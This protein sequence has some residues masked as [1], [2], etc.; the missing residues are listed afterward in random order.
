MFHP[1]TA[2]QDARYALRTLKKDLRFFV[3]AMLIIGLGIGASTAVF[4]V[5]SPLLLRPLGFAEPERLVWVANSGT[6]GMSAVTSRTSN[7]R[8][9]RELNTSF[10]GLTGYFAFFEA[11]SYNLVGDGEPERLVAVDVAHDFLDVLGVQPLHGRNFVPEEGLW[12]G[13][14]AVVLSHAFWSRRFSADPEIVGTSIALNNEPNEVVGVLPPSFDFA[15]TFAPHTRID[16]LRPFPISDET[17]R[18]G[19]TLSMI[20]RLKP[21][22]STESAQA[23]LD[24]IIAGLQEAD[25]ERWGLG[26]AVSPLQQQ[27]AGPFRAGLLLL[28]AAAAVVMLIVCVNLSNLLLVKAPKR[29]EEMAVR[30][31]LG[32]PRGRLLRQ[33]LCESLLLTLGGAIVGVLFA[34]AITRTVAAS[35]AIK[36]PLL[37]TVSVDGTALLFALLAALVAGLLVGIVPALRVSSGGVASILGGNSRGSSGSARST[38]LLEAL[39]VAEV[40]LACVLLVCGGLLLKSFNKV[41]DVELGFQPT[42]LVQWQI[43]TGRDFESPAAST[44]FFRQMIAGVEAIPGVEAAGLTDAAPLGRNRTWTL[45]APGVEYE[46]ESPWLF[47]FPH[48]VDHG[49][50]PTMQIPLVAGRHFTAHDTDTSQNVIILNESAAQAVYLGEDPL[51]RTVRS[52]GTEFEVVGI[53]ADVRHRSLEES[54]GYEMYFPLAQ[55]GNFS[56]LDL[57]VRS[58]LPESTLAPSVSSA[59][60]AV[61]PNMPTRDHQTLDAIVERAV[62]PRRF[63]LSLLGAFAG[64]ALLLAALG[65]YGVLSYSV[66]ERIPEI[67]IRMALGESGPQVL[68]RVVSKTLLLTGIGVA[69]GAAGSFAASRLLAS[70]LY[71]VQPTDP[72]TF[73]TMAVVLLAVATL[74][75]WIPA[76]KAARTDPARAL[77]S[78]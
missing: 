43:N 78:V 21:G 22:A 1:A 33:M 10:A 60:R 41:L 73:L 15:S 68:R 14:R 50:L 56:T 4:S 76:L 19:N 65:I 48:I 29:S 55:M 17:D 35:T 3:F 37:R 11:G 54:S 45:G 62:S 61:D 13:P 46:E 52:G 20:G 71:D 8:D 36:I 53:V 38:R 47:T 67:G 74:A 7:L 9:F 57:I 34:T 12:G 18:W 28:A 31:A 59:L 51:G 24:L 25:P 49:Y 2:V 5:M 16:F 44:A 64:V 77:R 23:E 66:A 69:V 27:I 70:L 58:R 63:T 32:A 39:V 75:G 30:T 26:A 72:R 6:G 40:A 42:G